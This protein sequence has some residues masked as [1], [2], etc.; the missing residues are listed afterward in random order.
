MYQ[1]AGLVF[2]PNSGV[3]ADVF[4][5]G[6][7][8]T[9]YC[10]TPGSRFGYG[11]S[12]DILGRFVEVI[13][14]QSLADFMH[15]RVFDP[16][17]MTDTGFSITPDKGNRLTT[18]YEATGESSTLAP[19]DTPGSTL[20]AQK[21]LP[22]FQAVPDYCRHLRTTCDLSSA[23]LPGELNGVRFP[24]FTDGRFHDSESPARRPGQMGDIDFDGWSIAGEGVGFGLGFSVVLDSVQ[25][26]TLCSVGEFSWGG[27]ASTVFFGA[28]RWKISPQSF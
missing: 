3:L 11:I 23:P 25:A 10:L 4:G 8:A 12:T 20:F 5:P 21:T 24:G 16:L 2:W 14:G 1:Q 13:S 26:R 19:V 22:H 28:I 7:G 15:Q 6:I 17:G 27:M 18:L 9:F